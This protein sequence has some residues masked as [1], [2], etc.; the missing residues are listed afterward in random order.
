[1]T[2]RFGTFFRTPTSALWV[3]AALVTA[4]VTPVPASA[5]TTALPG[6]AEFARLVQGKKVIVTTSDGKE[7]KGKFEVSS[8]GLLI[9]GRA[10]AGRMTE[11]AQVVPFDQIVRVTAAS[12]HRGLGLGIAI[13]LGAG[14]GL[15]LPIVMSCWGDECGESLAGV[16]AM[17]AIGA[18]IGAAFGALSDRRNRDKHVIYE[19]KPRTTTMSFAPI[20][21]KAQ[22]GV[23]FSMTWR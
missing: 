4:L 20:L 7:R 8:T 23:A 9:E 6:T 3:T 17:G 16:F 2:P 12:R 1:M 22:K 13:G 18:G 10:I 19:A 21:S 11:G 14:V 5:Q 15:S